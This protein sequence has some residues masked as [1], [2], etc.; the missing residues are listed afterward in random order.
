MRSDRIEAKWIE[1]FERVFELCRVCHG[2]N[3]AIL[4]ETQSRAVL[5]V[6]AG[7]PVDLS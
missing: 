2:E 6:D 5:V 7:R 3:V 1:A 4:S